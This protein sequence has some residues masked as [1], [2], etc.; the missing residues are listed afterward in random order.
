M[1]LLLVFGCFQIKGYNGER[2]AKEAA[3]DAWFE[4]NSRIIVSVLLKRFML[5]YVDTTYTVNKL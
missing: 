2:K 5:G 4:T 1:L 3:L